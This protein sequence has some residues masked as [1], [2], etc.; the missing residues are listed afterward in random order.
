MD[1]EMKGHVDQVVEDLDVS[2]QPAEDSGLGATPLLDETDYKYGSQ[3]EPSYKDT[4]FSDYQ[5]DYTQP[6]AVNCGIAR[7]EVA[8]HDQLTH[9]NSLTL[10]VSSCYEDLQRI[11]VSCQILH[12]LLS[13]FTEKYFMSVNMVLIC[14]VITSWTHSTFITSSVYNVF[15]LFLTILYCMSR[16]QLLNLYKD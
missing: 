13:I 5:E 10:N 9:S 14:G 16:K 15:P 11:K 12:F 6:E 1:P 8:M 7:I 3:D 2:L 4:A